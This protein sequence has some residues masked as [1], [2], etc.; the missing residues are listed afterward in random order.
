MESKIISRFIFTSFVKKNIMNNIGMFRKRLQTWLKSK[1]NPYRAIPKNSNTYSK[2]YPVPQI[3]QIKSNFFHYICCITPKHLTSLWV[4]L[5]VIAPEGNTASFEEMLQRWRAVGNTV[6]DV[7]GPRFA[8]QTSSSKGERVTT[9]PT[10]RS[11][12]TLKIKLL[13]VL[14]NVTF[15]LEYFL[16]NERQDKNQ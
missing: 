15:S 7:T 10:G 1:S 3:L 6:S 14:L 9:R 11:A 4:H 16:N 5:R 8:P 12:N 13:H 2:V